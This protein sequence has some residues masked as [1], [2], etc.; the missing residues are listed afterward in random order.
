MEN[1][2]ARLEHLQ[3][4][5]FDLLFAGALNKSI[6]KFTTSKINCVLDFR[7]YFDTALA[8]K[9][10]HASLPFAVFDKYTGKYSGSTPFGN[11]SQEHKRLEIGWTWYAEDA[12]RTGL[13]RACKFLLLSYCFEILMLNRVELKTSL[14]NE[15][16]QTSMKKIGAI[17]ESILRRHMIH[18][19][20]YLRDSVYFS[21][22]KE[23]WP[24]IKETYF[25]PFITN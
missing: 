24:Q 14:L 22:I 25:A 12:Q 9:D 5:H 2:R 16:S 15:R 7:R 17:Q 20:G 4:K 3:E 10:R 6:W 1:E 21:F 18:E 23:E 13:N 19:D 8:E 11:I